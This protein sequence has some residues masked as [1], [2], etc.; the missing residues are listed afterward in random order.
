MWTQAK[1]LREF[2]ENVAKP[3]HFPDTPYSA[4]RHFK[5]SRKSVLTF[6]HRWLQNGTEPSVAS[7]GIWWIK[8]TYQE[9]RHGELTSLVAFTSQRRNFLIT[10]IKSYIQPVIGNDREANI[11]WLL[12]SN[13]MASKHIRTAIR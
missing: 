10:Y 13:S 1:G 5:L 3:F 4:V 12:P 8:V 9:T 7:C 11:L 2:N 6:L